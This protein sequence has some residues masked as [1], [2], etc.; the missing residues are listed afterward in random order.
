[1]KK[2][3]SLLATVVVLLSGM[4]SANSAETLATD[5]LGIMNTLKPATGARGLV[6]VENPQAGASI[7]SIRYSHIPVFKSD[8]S[9][10]ASNY[11]NWKKCSSWSDSNCPIKVG[12]TIEG[13]A[14]LG[15]CINGVELGCIENFKIF[16][17]FGA[18]KKLTYVGKSF[19]AAIDI[20][21][22]PK[23]GMPRSS[24][25]AIYKDDEGNYFVIRASLWVSISGTSDP[26]YKLDVDITPVALTN[27]SSLSAPRVENTVDPRTGL[28]LVYVTPAPSQCISTGV[29]ICYKAIKPESEYKYSVAIRI[30]RGVSG[31]LRGRVSDA[32]F[33]VQAVND[34]SQLITV[35]AK[36]VKM[37]IAGGWVNYSE[38]PA[39]FIDKVW[40]SGGYDPNPNSSYFLVA[41]PSQ[42]DRGLEEYS[43]WTPYLK[44]K[45]LT[46]VSNW[47]FGTN[48]SSSDQSCL[49][50]PGEISGFVASNASVYSSKP[51]QWDAASSSLTYKVAA[52]HND[53]NG[54]Q[55]LGT[56]TLAMPL[57]S[58]KC[59]YGQSTLPPSATI[60]VA[61]GSEVTTVATVSLKSDSGWIFFS[62]NGFHYSNPTI[63]VKFNKTGSAAVITPTP[64]PKATPSA[65]PS[66][67][68]APTPSQTP[69]AKAAAPVIVSKKIIWCAKGNAKRK[70]TDVKPVCP[71][72]F[73]KIADPTNR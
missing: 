45:A 41:D 65:K 49:K 8:G 69:T 34:K 71:K 54:N 67:T 9:I 57:T 52:P 7:G 47:S 30:P 50:V 44:E 27:D 31:W 72:G 59:L 28:G 25:P 39:G 70:I 55:N 58:I 35:T 13:K 1:M 46:S 18:G 11:W 2:I 33:D 38:L 42:G 66:P 68:A 60:S 3:V 23:F 53:E 16:N 61:Y 62:A 17:S 64:T 4:T 12:H 43:A 36:P 6:F 22:E 19:A 5:P 73:K 24:S 26:T 51:P 29:G 37:P 14:I 20:P 32:D 40:P 15:I 21:E 63:V 10:E 56:Y 48:M